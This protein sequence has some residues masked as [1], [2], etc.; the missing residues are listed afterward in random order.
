MSA[1]EISINIGGTAFGVPDPDDVR[2]GN[3]P[4]GIDVILNVV[5]VLGQQGGQMAAI[6]L[7]NVKFSL[8]RDQAVDFFKTGLEQA[9][10][11]PP[12]SKLTVASDLSAAEAFSRDIDQMRGDGA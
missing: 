3:A 1:F 12:V 6:P 4:N 10:A 11:L 7:G 2:A 5:Q 9:E 8:G